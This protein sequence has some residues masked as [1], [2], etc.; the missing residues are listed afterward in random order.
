MKLSQFSCT[1]YAVGLFGVAVLVTVI[2]RWILLALALVSRIVC[3]LSGLDIFQ[4][5]KCF[6]QSR[7]QA[8]CVCLEMRLSVFLYFRTLRKCFS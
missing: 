4:G 6:F 5:D 1:D 2:W 8:L 3:F 7:Q